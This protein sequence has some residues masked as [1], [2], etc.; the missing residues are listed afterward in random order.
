VRTLNQESIVG[1]HVPVPKVSVGLPVYNGE[2]FLEE[3]IESSLAQTFPDFELII[4][5]NGSTDRTRDICLRYAARDARVRFLPSDVNHG[6]SWN[7]CRVLEAARGP[8]FRWAPADDKFHPESLQACVEILDA[9]PDVVLC[10]PQTLLINEHGEVLERY[11]DDLDFRSPDVRER[12]RE[13]IRRNR[14]VSAI[15]GLMRTDALRKTGGLHAFPGADVTLLAELTLYG[16]FWEIPRPLFYRRL[17]GAASTSLTTMEAVQEW[18]DPRKKDK[19][20]LYLWTHL[21]KHAAG[22]WRAPLGLPAKLA[23]FGILAR[24]TLGVRGHLLGELLAA[25]GKAMNRNKKT[26]PIRQGEA[27]PKQPEATAAK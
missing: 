4:S 10:Y 6:A 7:Y 20:F 13:A 21:F 16:R 19:L 12:F 5:D 26:T 2:R 15:Y 25:A 22:I 9:H 18:F 23:L 14:L 11:D 3:A 27:S 8:Y 24:W 1:K 17:H